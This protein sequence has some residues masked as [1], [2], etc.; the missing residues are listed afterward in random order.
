VEH[1]AGSVVTRAIEAAPQQTPVT[2]DHDARRLPVTLRAATTPDN[3][4]IAPS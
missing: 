4:R 3:S 1:Q 2:A